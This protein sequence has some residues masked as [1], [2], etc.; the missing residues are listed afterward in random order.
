MMGNEE[1]REHDRRQALWLSNDFPIP[2][3]VF[4]SGSLRG[5]RE[6]MCRNIFCWFF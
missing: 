6:M 3:V 5:L 1:H 2:D 4:L